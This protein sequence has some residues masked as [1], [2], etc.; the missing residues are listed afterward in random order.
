MDSDIRS[1]KEDLKA[2]L[3]KHPNLDAFTLYRAGNFVDSLEDE[4]RFH[5]FAEAKAWYEREVRECEMVAEPIGLKEV[6]GGWRTD[7]ATGN[8]VHESGGFLTMMGVRVRV[9]HRET[10]K[11]W[12]QPMMDQGTDSSVNAIVRKKFGGVY[13]Y[14]IQGKQ[15]PGNYGRVQ[16]APTL[17]ATF[18]NL[19]QLHGGR[20]PPF[21][22]LYL[23]REKYKVLYAHWLPED[24]GRFYLKRIY[25]MLLEADERTEIPVPPHFIWLT[26]HQIKTF[27][28]M[29]NIVNPHVRTIVAHM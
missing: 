26:L 1:F 9:T 8:L 10:G 20:R 15:E 18:S 29:D 3:G 22:E 24:G 2:L 27:L 11:G 17:Q 4:N 13:H 21:S 7:P 23:E 5:T 12:D 25:N 19:H 6:G 16:L 14:L 28:R